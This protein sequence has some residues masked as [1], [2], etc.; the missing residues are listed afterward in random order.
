L[1]DKKNYWCYIYL[2]IKIKGGKSMGYRGSERT[3]NTVTV[4]Q[5]YVCR[6]CGCGSPTY[7]EQ[8]SGG[9]CN[10]CSAPAKEYD[11]STIKETLPEDLSDHVFLVI[12]GD[13]ERHNEGIEILIQEFRENGMKVI[14]DETV[15]PNG[16]RES[17][18]S[19]VSDYVTDNTL[20]TVVVFSPGLI[21]DKNLMHIVNQ[22]RS[23]IVKK[24]IPVALDESFR[25]DR[26]LSR[27]A[28][29][30]AY[31]SIGD[32]LNERRLKL[33]IS[34]LSAKMEDSI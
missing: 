14:T 15:L 20:S 28:D 31:L 6:K 19:E 18:V 4:E 34:S 33:L 16:I 25:T 1:V 21:E 11:V 7:A 3:E 9:L 12:P 13:V 10:R 26:K 30:L 24:L 29:R 2:V 27:I 8:F 5:N 22:T 23:P 32:N 17:E